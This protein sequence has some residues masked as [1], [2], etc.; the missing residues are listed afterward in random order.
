MQAS[1]RSKVTFGDIWLLENKKMQTKSFCI[2][3]I[4]RFQSCSRGTKGELQDLSRTGQR[5]NLG[6]EFSFS[7]LLFPP[8]SPLSLSCWGWNLLGLCT[9]PLCHTSRRVWKRNRKQT[10]PQVFKEK[11]N[12]LSPGWGKRD[13]T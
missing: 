1:E 8:F 5:G 3:E 12:L 10:F 9:L 2:S 11:S 7:L 4:F 13:G 6:D